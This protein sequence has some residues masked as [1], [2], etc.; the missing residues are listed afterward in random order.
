[1]TEGKCGVDYR[2]RGKYGYSIDMGEGHLVVSIDNVVPPVRRL[3]IF[4]ETLRWRQ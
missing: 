2:C 3:T 4:D 1:M